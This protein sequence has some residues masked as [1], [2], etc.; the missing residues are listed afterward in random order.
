METSPSLMVE[1]SSV[2]EE[3]LPPEPTPKQQ[4]PRKVKR[5]ATGWEPAVKETDG[6]S[7]HCVIS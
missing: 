4:E 3:V 1:T 5:K 2:T 7:R 6:R